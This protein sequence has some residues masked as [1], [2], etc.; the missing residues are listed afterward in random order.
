MPHEMTR[1]QA[2]RTSDDFRPLKILIGVDI[3]RRER[4]VKSNRDQRQINARPHCLLLVGWKIG[5]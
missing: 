2:R 1:K 3:A 4:K 5:M